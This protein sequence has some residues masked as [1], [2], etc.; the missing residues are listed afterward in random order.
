MKYTAIVECWR[1][2]LQAPSIEARERH[3]LR[4]AQYIARKLLKSA[5]LRPGYI[6]ECARVED[7]EENVLCRYEWDWRAN[8]AVLT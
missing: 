4:S 8:C 2:D 7:S 6:P 3:S 1:E 5:C